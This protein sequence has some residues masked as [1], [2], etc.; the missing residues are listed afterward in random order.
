MATSSDNNL[1]RIDVASTDQLLL[2]ASHAFIKES[3]GLI[4][5]WDDKMEKHQQHQK[6]GNKPIGEQMPYVLINHIGIDC[7]A[8]VNLPEGTTACSECIDMM[9][10][11]KE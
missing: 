7:H 10:V 8:W 4:E 6:L 3:L 2:N 9:H 5:Q 11:L 1:Q